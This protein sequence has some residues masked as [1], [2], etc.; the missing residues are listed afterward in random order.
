MPEAQTYQD[1]WIRWVHLPWKNRG[2]WRPDISPNILG[3]KAL[4]KAQFIF[5][6]YSCVFI[7]LDGLRKVLSQKQPGKNGMIIFNINPDESTVDGVHVD[8]K[9]IESRT[10]KRKERDEFIKDLAESL[11]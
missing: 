5:D 10:K 4:S 11:K 2:D 7:P 3:N 1:V 9:V 6:D 8:L